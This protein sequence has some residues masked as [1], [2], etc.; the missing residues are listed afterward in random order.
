MATKNTTE[1]LKTKRR[2]TRSQAIRAKCLDCCCDNRKE[3]ELC[4]IQKCPLWRYRMGYEIDSKGNRVKKRKKD[5]D[6]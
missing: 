6:E 3:V 4:T 5:N 2:R 1:A